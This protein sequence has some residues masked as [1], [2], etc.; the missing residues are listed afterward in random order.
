MFPSSV[1]FSAAPQSRPSP[2]SP[3]PCAALAPLAP[4]REPA[5]VLCSGRVP[6]YLLRTFLH[7]LEIAQLVL[8]NE[9]P[10]IS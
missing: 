2:L 7:Y 1:G 10:G 8:C 6:L 3:L 9:I 5:A 4:L